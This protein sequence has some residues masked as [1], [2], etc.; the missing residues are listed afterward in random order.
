MLSGRIDRAM[1]HWIITANR[2]HDECLHGQG[3]VSKEDFALALRS[4]QAAVLDAAKS[5]Q[6]KRAEAVLKG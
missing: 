5:P 4:H 2:K 1:K 6:R 3:Y